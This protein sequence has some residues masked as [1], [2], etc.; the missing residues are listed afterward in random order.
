[1][2]ARPTLAAY[3]KGS[4]SQR[5]ATYQADLQWSLNL[6]QAALDGE[7]VPCCTETLG[8][9][10][11]SGRRYLTEGRPTLAGIDGT[12]TWCYQGSDK[13]NAQE[14]PMKKL[15]SVKASSALLTCKP[16]LKDQSAE[17]KAEV[18][19]PRAQS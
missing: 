19:E 1:M 13:A 16:E 4:L 12:T 8:G 18:K 10:I 17:P 3:K 15:R 11:F 14:P 6:L 5:P 2:C 9:E 7:D